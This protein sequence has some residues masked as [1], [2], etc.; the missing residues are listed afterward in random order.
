MFDIG[1]GELLLILLVALLLFGPKKIPEVAQLIGKG[2]QR[3][4][5]AQEELIEQV[6]HIN[7]AAA[8]E[9]KPLVTATNEL[10]QT[11]ARL[12]EPPQ[13]SPTSKEEQPS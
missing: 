2:V 11:I 12:P 5:R 8:E 3:M 10:A 4:R 9:V 6:R 1:G 7:T 13:P